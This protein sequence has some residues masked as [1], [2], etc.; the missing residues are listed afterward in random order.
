[1]TDQTPERQNS[2]AKPAMS[3]Q[4]PPILSCQVVIRSSDRKQSKGKTYYGVTPEQ[5]LQILDKVAEMGGPEWLEQAADIL[6]SLCHD[7]LD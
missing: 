2:Q 5:V 4:R 7:P 1:M 6:P 3:A